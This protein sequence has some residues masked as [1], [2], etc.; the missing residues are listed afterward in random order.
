VRYTFR[1]F[2]SPDLRAFSLAGGHIY[3]SRKLITDARSEDELAAMLAQEIGRVYT[4]HSASSV[5]LRFDKLMHVKELGDRADVYDKFQ[6]LLNVSPNTASQLTPDDQ[7]HDEL[8]ADQVGLYAMVRAQYKPEAFAAFLDRVNNNGGYTGNF[9]TDLFD[10]TPDIAIRVRMAHKTIDSLPEGCR[11]PR[12]LYR[13]GFKPFQEAMRGQ[14]IDPFIPATPGLRSI[15]LDPPMNPALENVVLSPD[16]KYML[17]Q[18]HYQIHVSATSPPK[19]LFSVPALDAEM[20]QFSPDSNYLVFNYNDLQIEKRELISGQPADSADVVDY[21]GCLQASLSPDGNVLACISLNG[22]SVWLKLEEV[23]TGQM[24]Y[25]NMHFFDN[26]F[27][28]NLATSLNPTFQA[29]MRWTRNGR[30][31]VAASGTAGMAYDL[32]NHTTVPLQNKL[33]GLSQERFAFVGSDKL[34]STCD[35][36]FKP[37]TPQDT[38]KMCY[39]SFPGGAPLGSFQLPRGW[40]ASVSGGDQLLFG[41]TNRSA[42]VI[43]DPATSKVS[44]EFKLETADLAGDEVAAEAQKG[45]ISVGPLQGKMQTVSLPASPLTALE[46]IAFSPNGRYLALSDRARGA[47]WDVSTGK[48]IALTE[49]FR[50]VAVDDGGKLQV[51]FVHHELK[52]SIDISIDR[53]THKYTPGLT[54]IGD[55]AQYGSIRVRFKPRGVQQSSNENVDLEAFDTQSE[56]RLW[57][58]RFNYSVPQI[59]PADGDLLL[60]VMDRQSATGSDEAGRNGKRLIRAQDEIKNLLDEMGTLVEIVNDRTGVVE[61][62]LVAPQLASNRREER[63]AAL[64][65][66]MVAVYGNSNNT[67]VYR[68]SDGAR[69][70]AFFGRA[71]AGDDTLGMIAATNRPQ[72]LTVYSVANGKPL[73]SVILDHNVLAAR[74]VPERKELLVLTATQHVYRL[75]LQDLVSQ[76]GSPGPTRP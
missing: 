48:Q 32:M 44:A 35:W 52:P 40:L 60:F 65:G 38:Y 5:T 12:P 30:Y 76:A 72:E 42:A 46:A 33:S 47:E 56:S 26:Y 75:D 34:I 68:A 22:D 21:A 66:E 50:A 41:P 25:Q 70:L 67:V 62:S 1:V 2:E 10:V 36:G 39:T 54:I 51:Q 73:T 69:L 49:P 20:A 13:R 24:L 64:F 6:R 45:G 59:I 29:L 17:G 19:L 23:S 37:G 63:I 16:G 9:F 11:R 58:T 8:L 53:R 15:P 57:S 27:R 43:F 4:H 71:L 3:I 31:F 14:R 55:P 7:M 61:R 28:P 74:F 18:D